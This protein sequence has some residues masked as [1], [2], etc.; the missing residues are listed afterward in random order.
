MFLD[1]TNDALSFVD[2][3][4]TKNGP[5]S[6]SQRSIKLTCSGLRSFIHAK[7]LC[8][9]L[10]TSVSTSKGLRDRKC[11]NMK[12]NFCESFGSLPAFQSK[13]HYNRLHTQN[14][15]VPSALSSAD[16]LLSRLVNLGRHPTSP[17]TETRDRFMLCSKHFCHTLQASCESSHTQQFE[18]NSETE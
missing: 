13:I 16:R 12:R 9:S 6:V 14:A 10:S 3:L 17:T 8:T 7:A 11:S 1:L 5:L 18:P 15:Q 4:N 2:D